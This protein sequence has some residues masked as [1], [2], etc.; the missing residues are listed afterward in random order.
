MLATLPGQEL[1]LGM[2]FG[3]PVAYFYFCLWYKIFLRHILPKFQGHIFLMSFIIL[4]NV[5]SVRVFPL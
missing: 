5:D 2:F 3:T 1:N 4:V